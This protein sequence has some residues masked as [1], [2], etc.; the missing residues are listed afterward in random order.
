MAAKSLGTPSVMESSDASRHTTGS[1]HSWNTS[2]GKRDL[3]SHLTVS[4]RLRGRDK[5]GMGGRKVRSYSHWPHG[6]VLTRHLGR[7]WGPSAATKSG[8]WPTALL[9]G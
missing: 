7:H 5:G 1:N 9:G 2:S 6:G 8:S 3:K 4:H